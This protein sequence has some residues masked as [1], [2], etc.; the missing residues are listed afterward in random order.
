MVNTVSRS[1]G[2]LGLLVLLSASGCNPAG[3]SPP[4]PPPP[5]TYSVSGFV[6]GSTLGGMVPVA[7]A[8]VEELQTFKLAVTD[9]LG[10]YT[11]RGLHRGT[12]T[13]K[14]TKP[15]FLPTTREVVV[16]EADAALDIEIV[17]RLYEVSGFVTENTLEGRLPVAGVYVGVVDCPPAPNGSYSLASATTDEK[18]FYTVPGMCVGETAIFLY[19]PGYLLPQQDRVCEGDGAP[20]RFFRISG[21][22]RLDVELIRQGE[23]PATQARATPLESLRE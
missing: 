14:V 22:T 8:T 13:L 1:S 7:G 16:T 10:R 12:V 5:Q 20:C 15:P 17:Q 2:V 18:G 3:I 6:T 21:D 11:L 19:K 9:G 23:T 4:P